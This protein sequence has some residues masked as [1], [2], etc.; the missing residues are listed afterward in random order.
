MSHKFKACLDHTFDAKIASCLVNPRAAHETELV[1]K[2]GILLLYIF[3]FQLIYLIIIFFIVLVSNEKRQKIA[4][5]G[6]G[7][8]GLACATTAAG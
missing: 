1:I 8:A 7:P 2:P 3:C 5:V 4:V 6:A